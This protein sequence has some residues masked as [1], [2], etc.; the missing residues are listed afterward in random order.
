V[1]SEQE[2]AAVKI[3][4]KHCTRSPRNTFAK[5]NVLLDISKTEDE[6]LKNMHPKCRYNIN[7]AQKNGIMISSDEENAFDLFFDLFEKTSERQKFYIHSKHYYQTIYSDLAQ[8]G[9]AKI[10]IAKYENKA[11]SA[12]MFLMYEGVL[13]Y[14]Y[15]GWSGERQNLFPNNLLCWEGV[16]MGKLA[17]CETF[18]MWGAATDVNDSQDPYYGFTQFKLKFGGKHVKYID[19]FDLI[20]D[21]A[22]Y[23]S[24]NTANSIRWFLLKLIKN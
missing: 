8:A 5:S 19:S 1:E 23:H 24:F 2:D 10:L 7:Y 13:Y 21:K 17:E 6:L 22:L 4:S 12:W 11:V 14:I 16:K 3:L 15:G 18:D 9:M 20:I